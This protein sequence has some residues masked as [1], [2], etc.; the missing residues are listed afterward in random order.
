MTKTVLFGKEVRDKVLEGVKKITAAVKV[1]MGANGKCVLIG[2]AGYIDGFVAPYPTKITKDGYNVTRAF[3]L[4]DPVEN[5]G[6]LLIK[7][8]AL[9]TVDMAGDA[10]TCTCVLAE[11]IISEGMKLIDEG[12]NSQELK[13]GIDCAVE[14]AVEELKKMST[15]VR[16]DNNKI[17]EVATV[18]ANNDTSIG[19]LIADAYSKIGDDGII[20]IEPSKGIETTI[21]ISDGYKFSRSWVSPLFINNKE[22]QIVEFENPLIL[23]YDKKINH[24]TQIER[25]AQF[26]MKLGRPLMIICEDAVDEGLAFLGM[27]TIQGRIKVCVVKAPSFGE[28]QRLEM[29][30]IALITGGTYISDLRGVSIKEIEEENFGRARKVLVTKEETVIIGGNTDIEALTNLLNELRMNLV[31]AKTE[32]EKAPIE[33]RIARLTGGVAVIEVG[34]ATETE[35]NEK[36]D[37]VDDAVRAVKSAISEGYV[38]GGGTAF[39]RIS[40]SLYKEQKISFWQNLFRWDKSD[41]TSDLEKGK[42]LIS[43]ILY[44]PLIQMAENAGVNA[45]SVLQKVKDADG[46][47]GYNTK[48]GKVENLVESGVIDSTKALRCALQNAA[49]VAGSLLISECIIESIY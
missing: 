6:A 44:K 48:T 2:D 14:L 42:K 41:N 30:D 12:V 19:R 37:R 34:A 10:T 36:L 47:F 5:R 27:N 49:S 38:A 32:E 1:T 21:K 8:A 9:K 7:E 15:P 25:A 11:A 17:F 35:L 18:S 4:Q 43:K 23:L 20:D 3:S 16:G 31:D 46:N 40:P 13:K 26:S 22:K 45:D 33:K 39:A 29:E 28:E 24:H